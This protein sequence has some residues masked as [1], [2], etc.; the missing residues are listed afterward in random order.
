[1]REEDIQEILQNLGERVSVWDIAILNLVLNTLRR[2]VRLAVSN[3]DV[4][5]VT[6][7][8]RIVELQ[9]TLGLTV[10]RGLMHGNND[11]CADS[12]LLLLVFHGSLLPLSVD[13]RSVV[14]AAARQM[15]MNHTFLGIREVGFSCNS[16]FFIC[17][18]HGD[19]SAFLHGSNREVKSRGV[20]FIPRNMD[21]WCR[22]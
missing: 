17:V 21:V 16:I 15:L 18:Y 4:P 22:T 20:L 8:S 13:E 5:F 11:C 9:R 12:L 7:A 19:V 14:C 2:V 10:G 6:D 1:M 3:A